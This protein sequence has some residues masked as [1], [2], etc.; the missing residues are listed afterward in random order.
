V[1]HG[2]YKGITICTGAAGDVRLIPMLIVEDGTAV[3]QGGHKGVTGVLQG[4]T[5]MAKE[6][7]KCVTRILQMCYK[8]VAR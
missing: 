1:I 8:S 7:H 6:C 3:L 5:G 4:V 2:C